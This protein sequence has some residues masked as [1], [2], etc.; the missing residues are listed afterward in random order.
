MPGYF[1]ASPPTTAASGAAKRIAAASHKV[2]EPGPAWAAAGIQRVPMMQVMDR[3]VTSRNP[4]FGFKTVTVGSGTGCQYIS[5][6]GDCSPVDVARTLVSAASRLVS[7][8]FPSSQIQA[9]Q[10]QIVRMAAREAKPMS[11]HLVR[12]WN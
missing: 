11:Y 6:L 9:I 1:T 7:T 4:S 12:Y 8:L 5:K 10:P 3:N 2:T